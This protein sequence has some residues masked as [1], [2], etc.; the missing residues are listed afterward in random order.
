MVTRVFHVSASYMR[1]QQAKQL[2]WLLAM[3][4]LVIFSLYY[5]GKLQGEAAGI[6]DYLVPV[7]GV[8]ACSAYAVKLGLQLKLGR[9]AYPDVTWDAKQETLSLMQPEG[10]WVLPLASL[11]S[12]RVQVGLGRVL[13][14]TL[15]D[16]SGQQLRL[17]GYEA[18][19]DLVEL[20]ESRL[21]EGQV[22]RT[23]LRY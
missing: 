5:L 3:L 10:E 21:P 11:L 18:L 14:V 2:G 22:V 19:D 1:R 8:L 9:A 12:M 20:F 16:E 4:G 13:A 17:E 23:R 7:L 6:A 15:V